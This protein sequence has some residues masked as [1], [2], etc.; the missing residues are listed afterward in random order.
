[1]RPTLEEHAGTV[2]ERILSAAAEEFAE[3]GFDGARI[4]SIT[5][6]ANVGKAMVYYHVGD[7][8]S[9]YETI[10]CNSLDRVR[11]VLER[12]PVAVQGPQE[13]LRQFVRAV[14]TAATEDPNFPPLL[15]R[16]IAAGGVNLPPP[17]V[18][19]IGSLFEAIRKV[20]EDGQENGEFLG[21]DPTI[22]HFLI[23][24]SVMVV[25]GSLALRRRL[26]D[27]GVMA[28]ANTVSP[29]RLAE[30]IA[31][32]FL[33]GLTR[34]DAHGHSRPTGVAGADPG[35]GKPSRARRQATKTKER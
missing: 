5:R 18:A 25:C 8:A 30:E 7:K 4:D 29:D 20:L 31:Y 17:V 2:R 15:L 11:G 28:S 14:V 33:N 26:A 1:M 3:L 16:E 9:L 10:F 13:Q 21:F 24:G 34:R 12:P 6:R 23:G 35:A 19:R 27:L 32:L 22:M